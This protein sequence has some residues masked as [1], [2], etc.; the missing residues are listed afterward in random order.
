MGKGKQ[1]IGHVILPLT[2]L[3]GIA[4]DEEPQLYKMDIEKVFFAFFIATL[5]SNSSFFFPM[6]E[7]QLKSVNN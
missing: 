7:T 1:L 4:P 2:E 3:E 5:L 6:I